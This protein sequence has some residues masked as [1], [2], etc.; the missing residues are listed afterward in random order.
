MSDQIQADL[1]AQIEAAIT[2]EESQDKSEL[3]SDTEAEE[4][5]DESATAESEDDSSADDSDTHSEPEADV[6]IDFHNTSVSIQQLV[7]RL[8][9]LPEADRDAQI[10]KLTRVKEIEAVKLAFPD[11]AL[12]D[13][14]QDAPITRKEYIALQEKLEALTKQANPAELQKA[15]DIA[16]K[17]QATET[18]TND[19][20]KG[21]M[22]QEQ[23]GANTVEVTKDPKFIVAFDKFPQL[24]LEERLSYACAM[25]PVA[26]KLAS[27]TEVQK[28]LRLANTKTVDKGTT[29]ARDTGEMTPDKVESLDDLETMLNQKFGG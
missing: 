12:P 6:E 28:Q 27:S 18:M 2:S 8:S 24:P 15:L 17:L 20:L 5:K 23:F 10:S 26:R 4:S 25:S 1:E 9:S 13:R 29:V 11:A 21:L 16:H 3:E 7:S 19:K 22:L 14:A